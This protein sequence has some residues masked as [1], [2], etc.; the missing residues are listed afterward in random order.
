MTPGLST[1]TTSAS[2]PFSSSVLP[3]ARLEGA[4]KVA[5]PLACADDRLVEGVFATGRG[6]HRCEA[7]LQNLRSIDPDIR[8]IC[9]RFDCCDCRGERGQ[10]MQRAIEVDVRGMNESHVFSHYSYYKFKLQAASGAND[11][12]SAYNIFSTSSIVTGCWPS[13]APSCRWSMSSTELRVAFS[14]ACRLKN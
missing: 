14:W 12:H 6:P 1:T 11:C 13:R 7:N 2:S 4:C 3:T 9:E 8:C 10:P 5:V